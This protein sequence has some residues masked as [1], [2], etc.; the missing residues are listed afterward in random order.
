MIPRGTGKDFARSVRI[1]RRT[2]EALERSARTAEIREVDVGRARFTAP[3]GSHAEAYFAN[4]AGAGI[5]GAIARRA[6]ASSKAMGGRMSFLVATLAVFARWRAVEMSAS[7]DEA[8]SARA[9]CSRSW[10]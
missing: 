3:D 6:N 5:S 9:P 4:F 2:A 1:P 8:S 7:V 10:P